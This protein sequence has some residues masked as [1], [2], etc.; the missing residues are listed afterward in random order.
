MYVHCFAPRAAK[1]GLAVTL[2]E[3]LLKLY[4]DDV[5]RMLTVQ[6]RMND[7]IMKWPSQQLYENKLTAHESVADHLLK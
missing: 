1:G 3:R 2:M 7:V 5:M 4:G 6:Y